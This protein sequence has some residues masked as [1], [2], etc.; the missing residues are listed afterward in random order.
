M[1]NCLVVTLV[2]VQHTTM[3]KANLIQL[4]KREDV[5]LACKNF[6]NNSSSELLGINTQ[7]S[8]MQN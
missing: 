6:R 7:V 5:V 3:M 4:D 1:L 2:T 8:V